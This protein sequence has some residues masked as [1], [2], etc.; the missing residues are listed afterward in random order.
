MIEWRKERNKEHADCMAFIKRET[1]GWRRWWNLL[2]FRT[3]ADIR[4]R[5]YDWF[6]FWE[7]CNPRPE[8]MWKEP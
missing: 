2:R 8:E 1:T 6:K 5:A 3:N 7:A 4:M